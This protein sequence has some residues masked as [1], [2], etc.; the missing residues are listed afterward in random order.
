MVDLL[1]GCRV[2]LREVGD[3]LTGQI[4]TGIGGLSFEEFRIAGCSIGWFGGFGW[5][6]P[7]IT[8]V[9]AEQLQGLGGL[10]EDPEWL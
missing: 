7:V 8:L 9:L 10:S 3:R 6:V 1:G 5:S 2:W 4:L